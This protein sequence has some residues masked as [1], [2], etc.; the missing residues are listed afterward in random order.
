MTYSTESAT[1]NCNLSAFNK[2]LSDT[3]EVR[4]RNVLVSPIYVDGSCKRNG[5]TGPRPSGYAVIYPDEGHPNAMV[6]L[7][8][9]GAS[10]SLA[11]LYAVRHAIIDVANEVFLKAR[12]G[13]KVEKVYEIR[14][15]SQYVV[16]VINSFAKD[17]YRNGWKLVG[18]GPVQHQA[19]IEEMMS[20]YNY[21][22]QG[23]AKEGYGQLEIKHVQGH[24]S[25]KWNILANQKAQKAADS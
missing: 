11:E 20:A 18:G 1:L 9:E 10:S 6:R 24:S 15:D 8:P 12:N 13:G 2:D 14:T 21:I 7:N 23:Y 25:D 5:M 17:W 19:L 4:K 16:D 3:I 22:N